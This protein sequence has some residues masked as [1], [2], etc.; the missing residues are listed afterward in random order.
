M[1]KTKQEYRTYARKTRKNLDLKVISSSICGLIRGLDEYKKA[2]KIAGYCPSDYEIN[3]KP[4]FE[5]ISK[6]WFLPVVTDHKNMVF[7]EFKACSELGLNRYGICEPCSGKEIDINE[8][9]I[10]IIPALMVDKK[11]YR[12]GYGKGYYDRFLAGLPGNC[13]KIVPIADELLTDGL[14]C[15]EYDIP[16]HIAVT[17]STIYRLK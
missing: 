1:F 9:D 16:A 14:P 15:D 3:I 11:G 6:E 13:V 17:Q 5:D 4:L 8:P 7:C 2:K 10:I 12:L